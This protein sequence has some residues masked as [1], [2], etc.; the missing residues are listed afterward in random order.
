MIFEKCY[1][2][3]VLDI[4]SE[5]FHDFGHP[6]HFLIFPHRGGSQESRRISPIIWSSDFMFDELVLQAQK[7]LEI[8]AICF[9]K[10]LTRTLIVSKN[11]VCIS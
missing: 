2:F 10:V 8:F 4:F 11:H 3:D 6:S 9:R 5:F 1:F 7:E